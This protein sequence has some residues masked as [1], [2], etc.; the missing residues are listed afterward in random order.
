MSIR[1]RI[2]SAGDESGQIVL[3]TAF[4]MVALLG[5]AT[6]SLDAGYAYD[7]R[8]KLAGSADAAAKSAALEIWRGNA[9][10]YA[11]FAQAVVTQDKGAGRIPTN[12]SATI[13]LCSDVGATCLAGFSSNKYVEVI[14]SSSQS[15]YV[16]AILNRLSLT[17]TARAVAGASSGPSCIIALSGSPSISIGNAAITSPTCA[18]AAGG[19]VQGTNPNSTITA[20]AVTGTTCVN[21]CGTITPFYAN[22]PAPS[23]PLESLPTPATCSGSNV[24]V[25]GGT[26]SAGCFGNVNLNATVSM[27]SGFFTVNGVLTISNN[28]DITG[29]NV[30]IYLGPT[31]SIVWGQ[32]SSLNLTAPTTGTYTGIAFYMDRTNTNPF[33][34]QNNSDLS[35]VGAFYAPKSDVTIGNSLG[36]GGDCSLIVVRSLD[37]G[38]GNGHFNN[39]CSGYSGSPLTTISLAE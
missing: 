26:W 13:R 39:N 21:N 27:G 2:A 18:V 10:N 12:T 15:T 1:T 25:S 36:N 33:T 19:P 5:M 17:P 20:S 22:S 35:I 28:T 29:T 6:F 9:A 16:G 24:S 23:D 7:T 34:M 32:H 31:A 4:A 8:N 37:I 11:A 3:L 38:N 30:T 14:L